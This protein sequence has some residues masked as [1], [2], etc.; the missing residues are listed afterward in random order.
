M[1]K[2]S[3]IG[4]VIAL[5][6]MPLLSLQQVF[7]ASFNVSTK[8][9]QNGSMTLSVSGN[10]VGALNVSVAGQSANLAIRTLGGSDSVQFKT[11][12]GTFKVVVKA[13]SLSDA[14][15]NIIE[16]ETITKTVTVTQKSTQAEKP[17]QSIPSSNPTPPTSTPQSEVQLSKEND[18]S[19]LTISQGK[20][21]PE[22]KASE[23]TYKVELTS[24]VKTITINAKTKD[25]KAKVSGTGEKELKIGENNFIISVKAE[26]GS[27]KTYTVSVY[28][29]EKPKVYLKMD[30]KNLGVLND[31][32]KVDIPKGFEKTTIERDGE[33]LTGLKSDTLGITLLYLQNEKRENTFYIYE[34]DMVTREYQTV[35]VQGQT[36]ICIDFEKDMKGIEGLSTGE[37]KIGEISIPC[38]RYDDN[39]LENY[40]IV[41]LMNQTGE[42]CLYSYEL[43]EGTLQKYTSIETDESDTLVYIL[44]GTSV[45]LLIC[46]V[47]LG[48]AHYRF[49]KKS[50]A[51]VKEY[52]EKRSKSE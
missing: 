47:S 50:I 26:N 1:K 13:V 2:I 36:Y 16:G 40:S 41:Y 48:I 28:V 27:K 10:V 51:T 5:V 24:D 23:T 18:L 34:N 12:V 21:S 32:S 29:T 45:I 20:L 43:T 19:S 44:S 3:K 9:N 42:K 39:R 46:V 52:Y 17:S 4:L 35:S 8:D 38:W 14:N 11:G 30:S 15:Y 25:S 37:V 7:A 33:M 31:F 22:F 6:L 49:K